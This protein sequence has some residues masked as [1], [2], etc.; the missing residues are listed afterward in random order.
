MSRIL[1]KTQR[2]IAF[3]GACIVTLTIMAGVATMAVE[4]AA[5][6]SAKAADA[7]RA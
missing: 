1:S 3:G 6:W 5:G 4:P 7:Q 2:L